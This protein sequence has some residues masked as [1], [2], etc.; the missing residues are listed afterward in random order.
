MFNTTKGKSMWRLSK[1]VLCLILVNSSILAQEK[2]N[3]VKA[4]V[5]PSDIY[6]PTI[7]AQP[8]CP[9]KIEKGFVAKM[10]DGTEEMFLQ[11]RN[12]GGKPVVSFQAY[13]IGSNG[14]GVTSMYPYERNQPSV[15]PGAV[16]PP[17]LKENSVEFVPLTEELRKQ[18]G[19]TGKMR[20]IAFF[21]ILKVEFQDGSS[22]DATKLRDSLEEHLRMFED[23]YE[24]ARLPTKD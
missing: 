21:M 9:L 8:D 10:L 15:L 5:I 2:R 3:K 22:Y 7:V 1:A 13:T 19:L 18:L 20:V 12:A 4:V 14:G 16:A 11:V 24:K 6:L 23:N 17:G